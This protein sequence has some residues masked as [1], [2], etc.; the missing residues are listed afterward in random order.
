MGVLDDGG[1][2]AREEDPHVPDFRYGHNP[3]AWG[4]DERV[5]EQT[6]YR[7]G[8]EGDAGQG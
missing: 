4:L 6:V 7:A 8:E 1:A 3:Q 2:S 5:E